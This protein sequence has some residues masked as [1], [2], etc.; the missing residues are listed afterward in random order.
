MIIKKHG[1]ARTNAGKPRIDK[2][3]QKR[4]NITLS[5]RLAKKA[6]KIGNGNISVGIRTAIEGHK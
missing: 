6:K 4:R 1:G 2:D 5:D 3:V